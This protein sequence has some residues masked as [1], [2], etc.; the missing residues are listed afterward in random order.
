MPKLSDISLSDLEEIQLQ[1]VG[2]IQDL[3][4]F[5]KGGTYLLVG[6]P[7]I[8]KTT[9][10]LQIAADLAGQGQKVLYFSTEQS[11]ADLK[12][13]V[14]RLFRDEGGVPSEVGDNLFLETLVRLEDLQL[15]RDHIFEGPGPYSDV[16]LIVLD[17]IQGGGVAP[18][19]RKAYK[20]LARFTRIAKNRGCLLY[21]SPSPRD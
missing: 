18:T 3:V 19:A 4:R 15:W 9:L 2:W 6:E 1:R 20:E 8:G 5:V 11:P 14:L 16:R 12:S 21:T 10:S 13:T 17:S 7:G